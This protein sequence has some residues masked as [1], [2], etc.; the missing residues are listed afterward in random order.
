MARPKGDIDVRILHA[1][2]LRFLNEGVDGASL[3]AIAKDAKTSIGMVYYYYPTKDELFLSVVEEV[4]ERVLRDLVVALDPEKPVRERIQRLYERIGRLEDQELLVF[5]LVVREA[6]VS[7]SRLSQII[8]RFQ[9]GHLPLVFRTIADGLADGTLDARRHPLLLAGALIG[10]G[11]APQVLR[12]VLGSSLFPDLD[13]NDFA[14]Q[15]VD[16]L[17]N[18]VGAPAAPPP[19]SS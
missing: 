18:G 8:S 1:A 9:R 16:I 11:A 6:L 14:R 13:V 19:T 2:R 7:S 17:L 4:Y 15:L 5:R 12:R 3:R 10:M